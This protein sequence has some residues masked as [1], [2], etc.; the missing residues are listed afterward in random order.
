MRRLGPVCTL[1]LLLAA[2]PVAADTVIAGGNLPGAANTWTMAGSPY[3]L[4]GDTTVPAGATLTIDPGVEVRAAASTD[5]QSSGLNTTR[6]EL[7]IDGTLHVN[8]TTAKP[9]TFKSS[10]PSAGTW[11]GVVVTG[12]ATDIQLAHL[13]VQS[14]IYGITSQAAGTELHTSYVAVSSSSSYGV[15]LRAGSPTLDTLSAISSGNYGIAITDSASPTLTNCVVR[16][17]GSMGVY[18]THNTAGHSAT[19]TNCTLNANG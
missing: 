2:G 11:Y 6:I 7:T 12:T 15:W 14:A 5:G 17:S 9:V 18:V 4:M 16:N 13:D 10:S 8:G 19:L 1:V 3:L